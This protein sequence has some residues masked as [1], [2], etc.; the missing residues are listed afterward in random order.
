MTLKR[1]ISVDELLSKR[2]KTMKFSG[3]WAASLGTMVERSGSWIIYGESGHGK[4]DFSLQ[5][6]KYLTQF[7]KVAYDTIEEGA[8]L[9]F[10]K[11]L[12]RQELTKQEK[13]RFII[14]HES[15]EELRLRLKRQK[16]PDFIIIDSLQFSF[17]TKK[18]YVDLMEEFPKKL[19]IWISHAEGK[20]PLGTLAIWVEYHADIKMRVQGFRT[21]VKSRYEGNEDFI[22]NE[23]LSAKYW[24]DLI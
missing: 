15:I 23:E 21:L 16:S 2:F 14:L 18:Q 24:N 20:K 13:R 17:I 12:N 19:F 9:T 7:G 11:A 10:Q 1:A 5:L 6:A 8:R 22:I 4:T 3:A